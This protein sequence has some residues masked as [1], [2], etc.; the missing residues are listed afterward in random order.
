MI[1]FLFLFFFFF[2]LTEANSINIPSAS[3]VR[4]F[5]VIFLSLPLP[6]HL[7]VAKTCWLPLKY[8]S[9]PHLLFILVGVALIRGPIFLRQ[10]SDPFA[11]IFLPKQLILLP[12]LLRPLAFLTSHFS[13]SPSFFSECVACIVIQS[14]QWP[15]ES[16][17]ILSTFCKWKSKQQN[18]QTKQ[19]WGT[20]KFCDMRKVMEGWICNLNLESST[21]IPK[22]LNPLHLN[23]DSIW[24]F[25][26]T[27]LSGGNPH[28]KNLHWFFLFSTIIWR[29]L[30]MVHIFF[31]EN[32]F[33]LHF[34]K[35]NF[36]KLYIQ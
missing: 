29:L 21:Q 22:V 18:K 10:T 34:F 15:F 27:S 17:A 9:N 13:S 5:W 32:V 35:I 12:W 14:S 2:T 31:S 3:K 8:F 4:K 23:C 28:L 36:I 16:G 1:H 19:N 30:R 33:I 20:E 6:C 7:L 11:I 24:I 26:K 25:W